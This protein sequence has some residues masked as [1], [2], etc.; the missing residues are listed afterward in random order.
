MNLSAVKRVARPDK[1][2]QRQLRDVEKLKGSP[3]RA[4]AAHMMKEMAMSAQKSKL[5]SYLMQ[6]LVG[7]Y[8]S[9]KQTGSRIND[10]IR[11][12]VNEYLQN[13]DGVDE[14]GIN[15]LERF[16]AQ[17]TEKL[18][19]QI[20]N[21]RRES[22]SGLREVPSAFDPRDTPS[23]G[24]TGGHTDY[25]KEVDSSQ[26]A[27][28][29]AILSAQGEDA[30]SQE[31]RKLEEKKA[32]YKNMLDTHQAQFEERKRDE[33]AAARRQLAA[34]RAHESMLNNKADSKVANKSELVAAERDARLSQIEEKQKR[35]AAEAEAKFRGEQQEIARSVRLIEEE[36][37]ND[38]RKKQAS[39]ALNA[40]TMA[41]NERFKLI[42]EEIKMKEA[43]EEARLQLEAK[44]RA[45][46]EDKRRQ[47]EFDSRMERAA[48]FA[49]SQ[50]SFDQAKTA[51]KEEENRTFANVEKKNRED[52]AREELKMEKKRQ[53]MMKSKEVNQQLMSARDKQKADEKQRD[54][55]LGERFRREKSEM[56]RQKIEDRAKKHEKMEA[57]RRM[58]DDQMVERKKN[59]SDLGALS[60]LE[61]QLNRS[62]I[63]KL[64]T[65][66]EFA[67]R[68]H[69]RIKPKTQY[70]SQGFIW[71]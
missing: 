48:K 43:A 7:Q 60:T 21:K 28:L 10:F 3:T 56:E 18:K 47:D 35:L 70:Q 33:V 69:D 12:A 6:Q 53:Y 15:A 17:G 46:A 44:R 25:A 61:A 1:R 22:E 57:M 23:R 9:K 52:A 50:K 32:R 14:S 37:E 42:K 45:E 34:Q 54:Y 66:P 31:R 55:E 5:S 19:T 27:V 40:R 58:L 2:T 4:R 38:I 71:G 26:W 64:E 8:G 51:A 65:N 11:D 41:E 67:K 59:V 20:M 68:V 29:N 36:K 16:V 24:S 13:N 49:A 30:E 62:V 63:E 39:M